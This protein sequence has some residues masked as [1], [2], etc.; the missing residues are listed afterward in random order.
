MRATAYSRRDSIT[1][2]I[3]ARE[4]SDKWK[5]ATRA[6]TLEESHRALRRAVYE[7]EQP[8]GMARHAARVAEAAPAAMIL[9]TD[10]PAR[11]ASEER[12]RRGRVSVRGE[13]L[14]MLEKLLRNSLD[15]LNSTVD[16]LTRMR[17]ST[18]TI[19]A[20]L[21]A[22]PKPMRA[23]AEYARRGREAL[24]VTA[25]PTRTDVVRR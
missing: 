16:V 9:P 3:A 10:A 14:V 13:Q 25:S 23:L 18:E 19:P 20:I 6:L 15:A 24:A 17:L 8:P 2:V 1:R 11:T 5:F 21:R 22:A 4:R 7:A 12:L